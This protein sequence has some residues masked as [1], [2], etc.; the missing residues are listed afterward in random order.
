MSVDTPNR[1]VVQVTVDDFTYFVEEDDQ[2]FFDGY[3]LVV[4]YDEKLDEPS[5]EFIN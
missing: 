3:Q 5:Y 1:P 4:N 2:W